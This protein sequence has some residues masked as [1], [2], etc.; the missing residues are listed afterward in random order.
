M[1]KAVEILYHLTCSLSFILKCSYMPGIALCA[2]YRI[3]ILLFTITQQG[4]L[5][6][7][8]LTGNKMEA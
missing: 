6:Y 2:L 1:T 7:S 4:K 8:E 3:S 5:Y